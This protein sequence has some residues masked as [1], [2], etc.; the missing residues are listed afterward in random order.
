MKSLLRSA[1]FLLLDMASTFFYLAV[2]LTTNSIPIAAVAGIGLGVAQIVWERSRG[3]KIE[4]MQW[5]SLFLVVASAIATVIT[6][7]PRFVMVKPS[8][9]YV[10]IGVVML[11]PGWM[12]RYLPQEAID[13]VPDIAFIFGFVWSGLMFL[14]AV[15]NLVVAFSTSFLVWT[16]FMS[17]YA[18]STKIALFLIQYATMR[19]I[20]QRRGRA[21]GAVG[22]AVAAQ[23]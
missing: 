13:H 19:F 5:M 16:A 8:V 12:N 9:I 20:G 1:S 18:L 14:S 10:I 7:D 21:R 3:K 23:A 11:K 4:T 6:K 15:V 17:A 22:E 2:F